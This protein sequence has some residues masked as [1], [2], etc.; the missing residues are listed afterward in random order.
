MPRGPPGDRHRRPSTSQE[1]G[2]RRAR[3]GDIEEGLGIAIY[4]QL[5]RRPQYL[6]EVDASS[7]RALPGRDH[8][9]QPFKQFVILREPALR[10]LLGGGRGVGAE[11]HHGVGAKFH[12]GGCNAHG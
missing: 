9:Y 7:G 8:I 5:R 4:Q 2:F 11:A 10:L 6:V 12:E 3:Y 1:Q